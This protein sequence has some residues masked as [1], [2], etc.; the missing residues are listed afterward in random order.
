M[1]GWHHDAARWTPKACAACQSAF[2]PCSGSHRFC[3]DAC[4][5]RW[6]YI[7]GQGSTEAQYKAISGD[8]NRYVSRLL[9]CGGRKRDKL[10]ADMLLAQLAKQ[11]YRCA[12]SGVP[13]TCDL[14]KG[15]VSQTNASV[16]RVVAGGGYT[17]DNIQFVCRA[18]NHW[19]ANTPVPD[20]VEWC[21]RVVQ[22]H[23]R[24]LSDAQGEKEQGHGKS[25]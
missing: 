17:V 9:H 5:G 1:A 4:R 12:L 18:L 13:L 24:T 21:R 16:D 10:S 23:D 2:T 6:K 20:F 15:V 11:N 3:S 25:T 14:R 22:H 19:R 8:W 7:T